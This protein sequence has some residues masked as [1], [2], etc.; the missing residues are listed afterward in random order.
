MAKVKVNSIL[1]QVRGK[2]GDLVFKRYGGEVIISQKLMSKEHAI[3]DILLLWVGAIFG[4]GCAF[5]TQ[6]ILARRLGPT[7]FGVFAAALATVNLLIPLAG[8]GI[9]QY[10]LKVFGTEGW[11][12][13]RW[14]SASFKYIAFSTMF[15]LIFLIIWALFG[16]NDKLTTLILIVLSFYVLGQVS[17]ELVGAKF[18]LEEKYT[19]LSI[20]QLMP[21]F[22]RLVAVALLAYFFTKWMEVTNIAYAY[23]CIA[24][25]AVIIGIYQL[26]RMQLGTFELKG[27]SKKGNATPI[28][29]QTET[30]GISNV[31]SN[32]WPFGLAGLFQLINYQ[33]DIVLVKYITGADAAGIYTV[34]GLVMT[35]VYLMPSTIYQKFLLPKIHRWA[36]NDR[37]KFYRVYRQGNVVMLFMGIITLLGIWA[38]SQWAIPLLFGEQYQESVVLLNILAVSAPIVFVNHSVGATLVTQEHMKQKVKFMGAVAIMNLLLNILLI[39]SYGAQAAAVTTVFSNLTLLAIYFFAA[40]NI[41]FISSELGIRKR[42]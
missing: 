28:Q 2:V 5:L 39:P 25:I 23:A 6:V 42:Q 1:K 33:S 14:L 36:N 29:N 35:A 22:A 15:V 41:V 21:H 3:K 11:S 8:F 37:A 24:V 31:I 18:Q 16:P 32:V 27:H 26:Y 34:A 30:L 10:W 19:R 9:P 13:T 7:D 17:L 38:T 12:A 20:W 4:A 40:Q